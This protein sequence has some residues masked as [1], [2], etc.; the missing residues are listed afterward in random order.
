MRTKLAY[1]RQ[2]ILT[3]PEITEKVRYKCP[4][5]DYHG[6]LL[7][8]SPYRKHRLVVGFCNGVYMEDKKK[9][10]TFDAG[11]TQIRHFELFEHKKMDEVI[12]I[13]LIEEAMRINK[14]LKKLKDGS[15]NY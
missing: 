13:Q 15:K 10:L 4:F 3:F 5:Y 9:Y 11:Q 12:L 14:N 7:Y 8:M 6:M 2:L 1:V